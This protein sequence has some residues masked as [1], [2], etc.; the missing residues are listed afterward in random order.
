MKAIT[1]LGNSQKGRANF[2]MLDAFARY[3]APL[4]LMPQGTRAVDLVE[5]EPQYRNLV[6]YL[7]ENVIIVEENQSAALPADADM[8]ILTRSGT[9]IRRRYSVSGGSVGLFEGKKIG[10]KKNLEIL[11]TEI[12]KLES[13]ENQLNSQLS[14]L[15]THLQSLKAADASAQLRR[16]REILGAMNQE[17]AGMQA[18]LE[19]TAAFVANFDAQGGRSRAKWWIR[20]KELQVTSPLKRNCWKNSALPNRRVK[21]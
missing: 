2:L 10:R 18:K 14:T 11:D 19:N 16:E 6:E 5:T 4:L 1:L 17:K 21:N 12:K 13:T 15:R 9:L 3:Q 20:I 8:T 7:L